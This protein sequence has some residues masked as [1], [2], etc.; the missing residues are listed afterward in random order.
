MIKNFINKHHTLY[1][2]I[3]SALIS[4]LTILFASVTDSFIYPQ[5]SCISYYNDATMFYIM[6]ASLTKGYTPY[7]DIFDHK[8]LYIWYYNIL[9]GVMGRP[10]VFIVEFIFISVTTYFIYKAVELFTKKEL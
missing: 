6:G 1:V 7:V 4:F 3:L 8:G 9:A 5:L 10:G 2:I